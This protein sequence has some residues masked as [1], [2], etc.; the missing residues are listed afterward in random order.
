M[1]NIECQ[2][3]NLFGNTYRVINVSHLEEF[4]NLALTMRDDSELM[5]SFRS[6]LEKLRTVSCPDIQC[7]PDSHQEIS[8]IL[9]SPD[10]TQ[11]GTEFGVNIPSANSI[12]PPAE[13]DN[14]IINEIVIVES[15]CEEE[16]KGNFT[17]SYGEW[18]SVTKVEDDHI[19]LPKDWTNLFA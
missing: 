12:F 6:A 15:I 2:V 7:Q 18:E 4:L 11:L 13:I 9:V 8:P 10:V 19:I 5:F 1:N 17:L 3:L 14:G 16:T